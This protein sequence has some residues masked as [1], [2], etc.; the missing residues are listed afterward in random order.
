MKIDQKSRVPEDPEDPDEKE[1]PRL[2]LFQS[3]L[4][5]RPEC[6]SK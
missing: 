3:S 1:A 5:L 6:Y 2:L 4:A